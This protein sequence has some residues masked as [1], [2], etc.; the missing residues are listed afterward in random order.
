M[1][2]YGLLV[3]CL[4]A[5]AGACAPRPGTGWSRAPDLNVYAAMN[6]FAHL[7][8]EESSLC[9]GFS[10]TLVARRWEGDFGAREAAVF[11]ALA[12]RYGAEAVAAAGARD[13]ARRTAE[14]PDYP[15]RKWRGDYVRLMRLLEGRLG[16]A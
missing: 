13:A 3:I 7:A 9:G 12:L 1:R 14:C 8:R 6:L 4:A 10:P 15:T 2:R 16:L 5:L 11:S